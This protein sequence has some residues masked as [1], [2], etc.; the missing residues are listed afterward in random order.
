MVL[1]VLDGMGIADV[2]PESVVAAPPF[3]DGRVLLGD[4]GSFSRF[5]GQIA[6]QLRFIGY[7]FEDVAFLTVRELCELYLRDSYPEIPA[8]GHR[9]DI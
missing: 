8:A 6:V 7:P 3:Y 1:R 2:S 4:P 9:R 5:L